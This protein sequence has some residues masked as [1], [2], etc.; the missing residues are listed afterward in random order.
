MSPFSSRPHQRGR[1]LNPIKSQ[2]GYTYISIT[3]RGLRFLSHS[4][5]QHVRGSKH[6]IHNRIEMRTPTRSPIRLSPRKLAVGSLQSTP[7]RRGAPNKLE[8]L[9]A[10]AQTIQAEPRM[11]DSDGMPAMFAHNIPVSHDPRDIAANPRSLLYHGLRESTDPELRFLAQC[12]AQSSDGIATILDDRPYHLPPNVVIR[13]M[14]F[15]TWQEKGW[16][17]IESDLLATDLPK[18]FDGEVSRCVNTADISTS[19]KAFFFA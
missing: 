6:R 18:W 16:V 19:D 14:H 5:I 15:P 9:I 2:Q 1:Q 7:G 13:R 10:A 17:K 12:R 4:P 3:S 11:H 8:K